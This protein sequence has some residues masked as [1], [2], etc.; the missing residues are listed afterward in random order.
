MKR[1]R[2]NLPPN[3][4]TWYDRADGRVV[5][6]RDGAAVE[7][8]EVPEPQRSAFLMDGRAVEEDDNEDSAPSSAGDHADVIGAE[9]AN[10][11]R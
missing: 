9:E 10:D 3:A 5:Q 7:S 4:L 6:V 11:G 8:A 2:F 1:L